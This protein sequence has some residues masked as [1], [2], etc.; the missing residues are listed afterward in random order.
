MPFRPSSGESD[1]EA[2]RIILNISDTQVK[3][4][5]LYQTINELLERITRFQSRINSR[6]EEIESGETNITL[7]YDLLTHSDESPDLPNSRNLLAGTN[8][9]FD[10]SVAN[11]RTVNAVGGGIFPMAVGDGTGMMVGDSWLLIPYNS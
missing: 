8:I 11:E 9:T 2:L 3:N 5:P 6:V 4:N 10:D 1:F 7:N